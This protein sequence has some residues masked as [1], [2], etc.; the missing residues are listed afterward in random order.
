M[1][2]EVAVVAGTAV[3]GLDKAVAIGEQVEAYE[4]EG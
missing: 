4:H 2:A 3:G 1:L